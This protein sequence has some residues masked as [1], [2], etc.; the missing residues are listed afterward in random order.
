[1]H[2]GVGLSPAV[3]NSP[4]LSLGLVLNSRRPPRLTTGSG[5]PATSGMAK[6]ISRGEN[7]HADGARQPASELISIHEALGERAGRR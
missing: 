7:L 6:I 2:D 5:S 1:M 3:P 4:G